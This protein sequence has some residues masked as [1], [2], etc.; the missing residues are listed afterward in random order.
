MKTTGVDARSLRIVSHWL[1]GLVAAAVSLL[2]VLAVPPDGHATEPDLQLWLPVQVIHPI[3][4]D[5]SISMQTELRLKDDI[6]EFSQLV[7]KPALNYHFNETWAVSIGYKYIDK[8][9]QANEH[10]IWQEG[11]FNKRFGDLVTGFQLRLEE[12]FIDDISGVIPRLRILEHLSHPIGETPYY[13]TGFGAIRVNLDNKGQGP[14]SGF[15]QSRISAAL[16]RHINDRVQFEAGYLW[17][18]ELGRDGA[19]RN[20]HA[21][22]F[23]L[24]VNTRRKDIRKPHPRDRYR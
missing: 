11:H 20:D 22:N 12:R 21:I 4:E 2:A 14:V 16:G 5:W 17:R 9:Q 23:Q 24:V 7:Y 1:S 6:S 10:D 19:D 8:H 15:E 18:Y 3:E 13:L